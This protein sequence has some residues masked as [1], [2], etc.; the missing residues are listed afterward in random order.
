MIRT[1]CPS[2][3]SKLTA[4]DKL[5]GQT[6]KCPKC[7][8]PVVIAAPDP[9]A[10]PDPKGFVEGAAA[11]TL[12]ALEMPTRLTKASRYMI[13]DS[14]KVVAFWQDNG[15]GWQL[16]TTAGLIAA[17]RNSDMLP[18]RGNFM[19]AE[20]LFNAT[21]AG[22]RLRG[23]TVYKLAESWAL[24]QL[25]KGDHDILATVVGVGSLTRLQKTAMRQ[26]I[27]DQMM[28]PVWAEAT[29]VLEFLGNTD[30][31]SSGTE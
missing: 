31:H 20:L 5:A 3:G 24:T 7:G 13:C 9:A 2:C 17:K 26:A 21:D 10:E 23:L 29:S 25:A 15:K 16:H 18:H 11:S 14:S 27:K 19:M 28:H 12:L 22:P 1:T 30:Y 4:K 8:G 6:R